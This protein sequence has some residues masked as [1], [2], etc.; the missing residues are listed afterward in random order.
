MKKEG[1]RSLVLVNPDRAARR[2]AREILKRGLGKT[3]KV[4]VFDTFEEFS[5]MD[6]SRWQA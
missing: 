1:L 5:A 4:M 2:R 6:R 3:T